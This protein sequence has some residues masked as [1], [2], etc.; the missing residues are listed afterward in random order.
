MYIINKYYIMKL[1]HDINNVEVGIDEVGRGCLFGRVY[2]AAVILPKEIE[3]DDEFH[4]EIKDSKKH[5]EKNRLLLD[6]YIKYIALDYQISYQEVESIDDI[7]ILQATYKS[8]HNSLDNLS[9]DIDT[10]L[11]D[12]NSFKPY[13]N[14]KVDDLDYIPHICVVNGDNNY[15]S[16]AAA[17]ILAKVA[18]DNYIKELCQQYPL[19]DE[20]YDLSNNKG[21]GAPKHI[22]GIHKYG[23]TNL[24]R[25]T[26]RICKEYSNDITQ[27]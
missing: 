27:L 2:S 13:M 11:V 21:Y 8:M 23:I 5:S 22:E 14:N 7:N 15:Q 12:G 20:Y 18:R 3:P 10:I 16:I 6:E 25:K 19:L 1:Y 24:H 9:I 26:F 4:L 17:S